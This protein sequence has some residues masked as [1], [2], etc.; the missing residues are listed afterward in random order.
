MSALNRQEIVQRIRE[1]TE[2]HGAKTRLA[3]ALGCSRQAIYGKLNRQDGLTDEELA[4]AANVFGID[5]EISEPTADGIHRGFAEMEAQGLIRRVDHISVPRYDVRLSAGAGAFQ[6]RVKVLDYIP[7]TETF[8][9]RKLGRSSAEGLVIV[10][11]SGDSMEPTI[12]NGDL[13][14]IDTVDR[15]VTD[16]LYALVMD[17][18]LLVKRLFRTADGIEVS[19]DNSAYRPYRVA[20]DQLDGLSI[21]GRVRWIA[22]TL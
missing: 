8:L 11:A 15:L 13:V 19:S 3:K 2:K 14:M 10:E 7:F 22:K 5:A 4:V 1:R 16:G 9:R 20:R 18:A 17:D 12:G 6:D 21:I